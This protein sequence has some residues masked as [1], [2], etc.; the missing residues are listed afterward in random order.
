MD[1]PPVVHWYWGATGTGKSCAV[2]S[3]VAE[4]EENLG[5]LLEARSSGTQAAGDGE[6]LGVHGDGGPAYWHPGGKW[7]QGYDGHRVVVFD[8]FR[9]KDMP[10]NILLRIFDSKPLWVEYKGGSRQLRAT[11]FYVTCPKPPEDCY[12]E[13]GEEIEQLTRRVTDVKE[14]T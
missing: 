13:A 7:W 2:A 5:R 9:P 14:F 10:F 8:D 4:N 1:T 12:L 6:E 3:A 11:E